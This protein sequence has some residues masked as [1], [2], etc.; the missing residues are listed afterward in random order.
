MSV[1]SFL[2]YY[3]TLIEQQGNWAAGANKALQ[4]YYD[5]SQNVFGGVEEAV[6]NA[7]QGMEDA[8]VKFVE[9]GKFS[10]KD[11]VNSIISDLA[12]IL[13]RK[14]ITGPLAQALQGA[15]GGGGGVN[16]NVGGGDLSLFFS[17]KGN[18]FQTPG[19]AAYSNKIVN[20]PT[21]FAFAR[22]AG[23]MGEAGPE[24]VMPLRRGPDGRLGVEA[25]GAA[26]G[27]IHIVNNLPT[28]IGKVDERRTSDGD[29]VII[30]QQAVEM[31]AAELGNPNSR[32]SKSMQRHF[33]TSRKR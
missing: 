30:L 27:A 23:L 31:V 25:G 12:R 13:I 22:G 4:D 24:A 1:D 6:G 32:V 17:A 21:L 26:G 11:L 20:S 8:L 3:A 33:G 15:F 16:P 29:R 10:F 2:G 18:V 28:A 19:L 7:M 14:N 5:E 9:T